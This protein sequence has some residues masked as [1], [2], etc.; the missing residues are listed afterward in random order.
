MKLQPIAGSQNEGLLR[1]DS[2][3][4]Y[5]RKFRVEKGEIFRS[6]KTKDL[7]KARARRDDM[8]A[9]LW[10]EKQIKRRIARQTVGELWVLW[11]ENK[12]TTLR[13][14][15]IKSISAAW[16]NLKP[17]AEHMFIDDLT[18]DWWLRTYIPEKRAETNQRAAIDNSKRKF[19]NEWKWLSMF[20]KWADTGGHG[21]D[22]WRRPKLINPDKAT[23]KGVVYTEDQL[24]ELRR[25]ANL[26][27]R[28]FLEAGERHFMRRSEGR[29]LEWSRVDMNKRTITLLAEHT[30]TKQE[31]TYTFNQKLFDLFEAIKAEQI[32]REKRSKFVFDARAYPHEDVEM[33]MTEFRN[34]W[35]PLCKAAGLPKGSRY[36]WMRH[37]GL[38]KAVRVPGVNHL[39]LCLFAGLD[40]KEL[41]DTYLHLTI[42]DLRGIE[43]LMT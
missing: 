9:E 32:G 1:S 40:I 7:T 41:Q 17:R 35:E 34:Q 19:F 5:F 12:K 31:R 11:V 28:W 33:T 16:Y 18:L 8:M 6:C 29:C 36:H 10:G 20:L 4:I 30:K 42:D 25:L 38:T 15:S 13:D 2:G 22:G 21:P 37:T 26:R 14:S 23:A 3:I 43:D 27:M 39:K 24:S